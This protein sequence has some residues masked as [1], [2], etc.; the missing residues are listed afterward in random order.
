MTDDMLRAIQPP[1][2]LYYLL[3]NSFVE[4]MTNNL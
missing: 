2:N 3:Q 4:M 1:N